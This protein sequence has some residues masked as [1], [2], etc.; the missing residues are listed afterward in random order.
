MTTQTLFRALVAAASLAALSGPVAAD[1]NAEG[2]FQ[3]PTALVGS[4]RVTI[5][6][7]NCVTLAEFPQFSFQSVLMFNEGGTLLETT[8]NA[9]FAPGQRSA[10]FGYWERTGPNFYHAVIEAF[11]QFTLP[12]PPPPPQ[13]YYQR[14]RQVLTQGIE[15][16]DNDRWQS[17][18]TV[19]FFDFS[20]TQTSPSGC[21]KAVGTRI[22]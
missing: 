1:G 5:T 8:S 18:A 6:P 2:R 12:A 7:Y 10:G 3:A 13:P 22:G 20:G 4:W 15:M 11:I 17:L 14:G 9:N 19:Q 21:A 16:V